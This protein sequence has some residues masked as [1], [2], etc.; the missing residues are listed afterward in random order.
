LAQ[1]RVFLAYPVRIDNYREY[2]VLRKQ[3]SALS[4]TIPS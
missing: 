1:F 2:L 4:D 3:F